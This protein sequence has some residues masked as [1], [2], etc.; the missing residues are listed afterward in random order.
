V[1]SAAAEVIGFEEDLLVNVYGWTDGAEH[2]TSLWGADHQLRLWQDGELVAD[3]QDDRM[4]A[5]MP[6]EPTP[7]RLEYSGTRHDGWPFAS[8]VSAE[9]EFTAGPGGEIESRLPLLDVDYDV[10]GLGLD[11]TAPR[12]TTITINADTPD[13]G[14][15]TA[16]ASARVRWSVD[17]GAT[18]RRAEARPK[19]GGAFEVTIAAPR[20]T[21]RV[22]LDVAASNP[23]GSV[24]ETTIGAYLVGA[25]LP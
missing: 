8:R 16:A 24:H 2:T 25:G 23:R 9:W 14:R 3:A 4:F 21:E 15:G 22:S 13:G 19:G 7:M 1:H 11:G 18:W 20:G 5:T 10:A 12:R 6:Q 17:D